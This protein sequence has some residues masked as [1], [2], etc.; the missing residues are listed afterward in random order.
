MA[1]LLN[2]HIIKP[3]LIRFLLFQRGRAGGGSDVNAEEFEVQMMKAHYVHR[4]VMRNDRAE[5]PGPRSDN[6][7]VNKVACN[8]LSFRMG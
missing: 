2:L 8:M 7:I 4:S 1:A 6:I 3:N 5:M